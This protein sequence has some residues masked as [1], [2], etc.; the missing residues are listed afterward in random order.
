AALVGL[1]DAV[2]EAG[3]D[4]AAAAPDPRHRAEVDVPAVLLRAGCDLVEAL[5]VGDELRGVQRL[6]EIVDELLRVGDLERLLLALEHAA[7]RLALRGRAGGRAGEGGLR[8]AGDR[9]AE[10]QGGLHG[11]GAGALL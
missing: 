1:G 11:P 5:G 8:D 9:D 3:A 4:D 10:V 2:E 6:L 7:G